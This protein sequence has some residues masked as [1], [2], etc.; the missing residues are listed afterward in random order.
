MARAAVPSVI[1]SA[2]LPIFAA[3]WISDGQKEIK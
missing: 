3:R 2:V 1:F